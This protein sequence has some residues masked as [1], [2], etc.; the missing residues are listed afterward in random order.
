MNAGAPV[1]S[2][3]T[4]PVRSRSLGRPRHLAAPTLSPHLA[5]ARPTHP[6]TPVVAAP[7]LALPPAA[8]E[9]L[10][11]KHRPTEIS[12]V[13]G[14]LIIGI[15]GSVLVFGASATPPVAHA[16]IAAV[17]VTSLAL[18]RSYTPRPLL[19]ESEGLRRIAQATVT[20]VAALALA[21]ALA[22]DL[23]PT[24]HDP[25]RLLLVAV[26]LTAGGAGHRHVVP[27][28]RR[29]A[30]SA[31]SPTR[32]VVAGHGRDVTRVLAE[33]K[34]DRRQALA[35][36][37][38]CLP[39]DSE[40]TLDVPVTRG[41]S[42]LGDLAR[43]ER[44]DV[45][46]VLPCHHFDPLTLRRLGWQ[47]EAQGTHLVVASGLVDV[48]RPRAA[49]VRAGGM[50]LVH[51]RH[52]ARTGLRHIVKEVWERSAA[53]VAL[54]LLSP[55]LAGLALAVRCDSPGPALFRQVRVGKDGEPFTMLKFRTMTVDAEQ[56]LGELGG[57]N[58]ANGLLFKVRADPRITRIGVTLRRY[59][60]D[61]LPQ[62]VNV[63]R[64]EMSLVG[65][66]PPL[67]S[68]VQGYDGDTL[69]RLGVRP[70]MTGLWQVSGRSDLPWA[71]TV[72]LDLRYVDNWSLA[73]D[74]QIIVRTVR[75]VLG[76]RGAY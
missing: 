12:A 66:R 26:L 8:T 22:P 73:L 1:A 48:D 54:V 23:L 69:R 55:V 59:S 71:Q 49:V 28:V 17:W 46:V 50:H 31:A 18:A 45:V 14:D 37:A 9:P 44:P 30:R 64:G 41:F 47:L 33:L 57:H 74:A 27:L 56:R 63:V 62:L 70:G 11:A 60:V 24:Q 36:T 65:P 39:A 52:P 6:R 3:P 42:A 32:V 4:A 29:R 13:F 15:L 72:R 20:L 67:E 61:E 51:V 35:V 5:T 76:H 25:R 43:S 7:S 2:E 38:A 75:A 68:E 34:G 40:R 10:R 19:E 21:P 53:A 58:E 16:L